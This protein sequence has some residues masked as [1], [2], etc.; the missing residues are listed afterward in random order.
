MAKR[1]VLSGTTLAITG[2][3]LTD[4]QISVFTGIT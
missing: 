3:P 2:A 1:A 4:G